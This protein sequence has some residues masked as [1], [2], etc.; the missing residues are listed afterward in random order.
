MP[1]EWIQEQNGRDKGRIS[2]LEDRIIEMNK[3]EQWGGN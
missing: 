3:P 1:S 2:E